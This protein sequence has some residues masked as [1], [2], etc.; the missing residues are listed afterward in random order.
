MAIQIK[1]LN[2]Y[3]INYII[4]TKFLS[5]KLVRVKSMNLFKFEV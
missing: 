2:S 4:I 1:I 3:N 5:I